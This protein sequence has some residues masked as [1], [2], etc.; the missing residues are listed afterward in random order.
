MVH[1]N[2]SVAPKRKAD[3]QSGVFTSIKQHHFQEGGG[4]SNARGSFFDDRAKSVDTEGNGLLLRLERD[5]TTDNACG[6]LFGSKQTC[7][8]QVVFGDISAGGSHK[9]AD[10]TRDTVSQCRA[11]MLAGEPNRHGCDTGEF[12]A[13]T[14]LPNHRKVD[15][16]LAHDA[17]E[18]TSGA[19]DYIKTHI[20]ESAVWLHH[21]NDQVNNWRCRGLSVS[22]SDLTKHTTRLELKDVGGHPFDAA[23]QKMICDRGHRIVVNRGTE[24]P[25]A[26]RNSSVISFISVFDSGNVRDLE[27]DLH[28]TSAPTVIVQLCGVLRMYTALQFSH[29]ARIKVISLTSARKRLVLKADRSTMDVITVGFGLQ[30]MATG[31]YPDSEHRY[32]ASG[33]VGVIVCT[34]IC[35]EFSIESENI[36]V[37]ERDDTHFMRELVD[38]DAFMCRI[39][40]IFICQYGNNSRPTKLDH[41]FGVPNGPDDRLRLRMTAKGII[42]GTSNL[43]DLIS[44]RASLLQTVKHVGELR[45]TVISPFHRPDLEYLNA[46]GGGF[47]LN[48]EA[49]EA[50]LLCPITSRMIEQQHRRLEL[51]E[52]KL[53]CSFHERLEKLEHQT[54]FNGRGRK[55]PEYP[56]QPD[57]SLHMFTDRLYASVTIQRQWRRYKGISGADNMAGKKRVDPLEVC[58]QCN[59]TIENVNH[60]EIGSPDQC[61]GFTCINCWTTIRSPDGS[62]AIC[63]NLARERQEEWTRD[64][65][66]QRFVMLWENS[67]EINPVGMLNMCKEQRIFTHQEADRLT[68]Y[69]KF[70]DLNKKQLRRKIVPF[71]IHNEL[72]TRHRPPNKRPKPPPGKPVSFTSTQTTARPPPPPPPR[73]ATRHTLSDTKRVEMFNGL[74]GDLMT[75]VQKIH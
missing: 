11:S 3:I 48:P 50:S 19:R 13:R 43:G 46:N 47:E 38:N 56:K 55:S 59:K 34:C 74:I 32:G 4:E 30:L 53:F 37:H 71:A 39:L 75:S 2:R 49:L 45:K 62:S 22:L 23:F 61:H 6:F 64:E 63:G 8:G 36:C 16:V 41:V 33:V 5:G 70:K 66:L 54:S 15:G 20:V 12:L 51:P 1:T 60:C 67:S 27:I 28:P 17:Q 14:I 42:E 31:L 65:L 18:D 58:C 72:S 25:V 7:R 21:A 9:C 35:F 26:W 68:T 52:I 10:E 69:S 24:K 40:D 29:Q 44:S 73:P 57:L